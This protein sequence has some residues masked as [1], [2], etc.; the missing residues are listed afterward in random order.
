VFLVGEEGEFLEAEGVGGEGVD[1][2]ALAVD[3]EDG[4]DELVVGVGAAEDE[5]V[6]RDLDGAVSHALVV[7]LGRV[8]EAAQVCYFILHMI[9]NYILC[10]TQYQCARY[11]REQGIMNRRMNG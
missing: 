6:V 7:G 1:E 11:T 3:A 5:D 8:E 9:C 10:Q 4:G 2:Y